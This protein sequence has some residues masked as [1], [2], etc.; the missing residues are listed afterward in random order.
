[1]VA[2]TQTAGTDRGHA[3]A[4]SISLLAWV[5]STASSALKT[6]QMARMLS[7]LSNMSDYQLAEIGISRSD[8]P[9]YAAKLMAD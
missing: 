8:I 9:E 1:M 2:D 6:L 3:I 4:L 5:G 7:T